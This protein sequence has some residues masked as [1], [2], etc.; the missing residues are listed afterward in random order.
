MS[1]CESSN[2]FTNSLFLRDLVF[3]C[4]LN[5]WLFP[6][7]S[8]NWRRYGTEPLVLI[9]F[10]IW[11]CAVGM[12]S[13]RETK[14][15]R[16]KSVKSFEFSPCFFSVYNT[17][18]TFFFDIGKN[19]KLDGCFFNQ[20]TVVSP[21]GPNPS[22]SPFAFF[23]PS[24]PRKGPKFEFSRGGQGGAWGV[25]RVGRGR[26][27]KPPNERSH[28]QFLERGFLY[29]LS[30]GWGGGEGEDMN[31][32]QRKGFIVHERRFPRWREVSIKSRQ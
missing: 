17:H 4:E 26:R 10:T 1:T 29:P 3:I 21:F 8:Q 19:K 12:I 30:S 16:T 32:F 25:G 5:D 18:I 14:R 28:S 15:S 7:L 20:G 9:L 24:L 23:P 2:R 22:M 27:N 31:I 6:D 13:V 11:R